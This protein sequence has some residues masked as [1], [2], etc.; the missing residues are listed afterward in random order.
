MQRRWILAVALVAVGGTIATWIAGDRGAA[1]APTIESMARTDDGG[2]LAPHPKALADAIAVETVRDGAPR[3]RAATPPI[4]AAHRRLDVLV[5]DDE[6]Q[7]LAGL[8]VAALDE[9]GTTEILGLT[10][11]SGRATLVVPRARGGR[12]LIRRAGREL[13]TRDLDSV[14][15]A[16]TPLR[17]FASRRQSLILRVTRD[18]NPFLPASFSAMAGAA[19][20]TVQSTMPEDGV[21][22]G[23][24]EPPPE[25]TPIALRFDAPGFPA[26]TLPILEEPS[27]TDVEVYVEL[28]PAG[29]PLSIEERAPEDFVI[30]FSIARW[31]PQSESWKLGRPVAR[32]GM[33]YADGVARVTVEGLAVGRYL[34]TEWIV[35]A[36]SEPFKLSAGGAPAT[37]RFD[38]PR[39]G[40][41]R[42][43][44]LVP[45]ALV[46]GTVQVGVWNGPRAE[47]FPRAK[48][49][50]SGP[51]FAFAV[52]IP[53]DRPV[54]LAALSA[55]GTGY[56][57]VTLV[58]P[59]DGIE[60]RVEGAAT[61]RIELEPAD[62]DP[63]R[64][65]TVFV[66]LWDPVARR[67]VWENHAVPDR[68]GF[69]IGGFSPGTY[70]L[71]FDDFGHAP[72]VVPGATLGAGDTNLG[73]H[74]LS[75]GQSMRIR[76]VVPNGV[77]VPRYIQAHAERLDDPRIG[78]WGR[79]SSDDWIRGLVPGR[80]R[81]IFFANG[82]PL[83][84]ATGMSQIVE[85][86]EG[87]E[88]ETTLT[89][90]KPPSPPTP[91]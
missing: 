80:Y 32:A 72:V 38:F 4:D 34:V 22:V 79:W 87:Q 23:S 74:K 84:P 1:P 31:D 56:G 88:A 40:M 17:L 71:V 48:L 20:V 12:V 29:P 54:T 42:G 33:T 86:V 65:T 27:H 78:V 68:G 13:A 30:G 58:E 46:E 90:E 19:K 51:D 5:S 24:F 28:D 45:T 64:P 76:R 50:L 2:G 60:L 62:G 55:L 21:V 66:H 9:A 57:A 82:P 6:G 59:R 18:G 10:D 16:E 61:A 44:V 36:N 7:P 73:R 3:A 85:V 39:A 25:P 89:F 63:W 69:R 83:P 77:V 41:A 14:T 67:I 37:V 91:K 53:G 70:D 35:G 11:A 52:Q 49:S 8:T 15:V 75:Y 26:R 81:V 47:G 43:R